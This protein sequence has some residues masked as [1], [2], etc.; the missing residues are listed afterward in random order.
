[1]LQLK[2]F[3]H[4]SFPAGDLWHKKTCSV[5]IDDQSCIFS[6]NNS[7]SNNGNRHGANT[8]L[9]IPFKKRE[10]QEAQSSHQLKA[11]LK[12]TLTCIASCLIKIQYNS[13]GIILHDSWFSPMNCFPFMC[14]SAVCSWI[15]FSRCVLLQKLR[16]KGLKVSSTCTLSP[17]QSRLMML[18]WN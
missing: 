15:V 5:L 12:S 2:F 10:K 1:M 18:P 14:N 16:G 8:S 9:E 17:F 7:S 4:P 6:T 11:I 13:L 3:K